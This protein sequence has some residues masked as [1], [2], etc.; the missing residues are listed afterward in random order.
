[1]KERT[2]LAFGLGALA[3]GAALLAS[4]GTSYAPLATVP[5]VDLNRYQGRWY[6]IARLPQFF[7]KDCYCVYAEY[8]PT[9]DGYVKVYNSCRKGSKAGPLKDVTGKAFPVEGSNNSKLRVQFFWPFRGDYW[10]LELDPEYKYVMV[11]SP[12]RESLWILS[13]TSTIDKDLY[14]RLLDS[15][16]AKGFPIDQLEV[17][18]HC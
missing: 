15:A 13:R 9:N 14:K 12:D 5:S 8:T 2:K 11:G 7:E 10:V 3:L 4:C 17:T 16:K 6:E 1:M 18:E